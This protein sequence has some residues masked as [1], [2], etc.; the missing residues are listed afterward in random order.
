MLSF[1]HFH[2]KILRAR[3]KSLVASGIIAVVLLSSC[4]IFK[5]KEPCK[6]VCDGDVSFS[7]SDISLGGFSYDMGDNHSLVGKCGFHYVGD[8]TGGYGNTLEVQSER[9][10]IH[11]VWAF[12]RLLSFNFSRNYHGKIKQTGIRV[13]DPIARFKAAYPDYGAI[14]D[15]TV[16]WKKITTPTHNHVFDDVYVI[17]YVDAHGAINSLSINGWWDPEIWG[18]GCP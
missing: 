15:S 7:P 3:V 9:C 8:A 12:Y 6:D 2:Q 4:N 17:A 18:S 14:C 16:F 10:G 5:T 13:G 11:L 1:L